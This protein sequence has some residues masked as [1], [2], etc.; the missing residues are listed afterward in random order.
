MSE[1]DTV[2][3]ATIRGWARKLGIPEDV[4]KQRCRGLPRLDCSLV[5]PKHPDFH[6][7]G[8]SYAE[9][10]VRTACADLLS[11]R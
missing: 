4:L 10:D 11:G 1:G 9:P 5:D 6:V 3:Y 2:R 7:M 8:Q